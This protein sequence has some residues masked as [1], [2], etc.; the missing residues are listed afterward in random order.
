MKILLLS[1]RTPYPPH[2]GNQ[3]RPFNVITSLTARGHDVHVLAFAENEKELSQ[4]AKL[5]EFCASAQLISFNKLTG[6]I[7]AGL[8]LPGSRSLSLG[9]FDSRDMHRA[10]AESVARHG[11]EA[12]VVYS[13]T[14]CQF[15][16]AQ[17]RSRTVVDMADV[18]SEK[19]MDYAK[20]ASF[21]MSF[22]YS[23]EGRRLRKYEYE[24]IRT[25]AHTSLHTLREIA[26][27]DE[28]DEFTR[29]TRL[30]PITNGVNLEKF[31][32][33]AFPAF[34]PEALP[35]NER[36]LLTDP[37]APRIVF[38]GAMDYFPNAEAVCYFADEIFP[39]IQQRIPNAQFLIV[40]SDPHP[41]V[42]KLTERPGIIVTGFVNDVRPY[43]TAAKVCVIPLR[44]ARGV[45]N[46]ALEAMAT[47]RVVIAT[48][49]VITGV[50]AV[51][52]EHLLL[53]RDS[54]EFISQTLKVLEDSTFRESLE[55]RARRFVEEEY[56]WQPLMDRFAE[57]VESV[58]P[59]RM[60]DRQPPVR[61]R[62]GK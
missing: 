38:T 35:E 40:G 3:I 18:D 31:H 29:R 17:F 5:A 60:Q 21:P 26:V 62:S 33:E 11:I 46:K 6:K 19:W 14:M 55:K 56:S 58:Q 36:H 8:A 28:L 22:I 32:P 50:Q 54:Q 43:L 47:G 10:V 1:H 41:S 7:R 2:K 52:D 39:T 24:I 4:Q 57:L 30:H 9:Y 34:A 12:F 61:L 25:F 15:V 42:I 49:D 45:Q 13:S 20:Q 44:I 53:A 51:P 23:T 37:N 48:P 59:G 16:P 27:L